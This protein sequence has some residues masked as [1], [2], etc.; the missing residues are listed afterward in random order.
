MKKPVPITM[1]I[2][3]LMTLIVITI[4][5]GG[6]A[7]ADGVLKDDAYTQTSTP[8]QN[9]GGNANLRV[10]SGIT[11]HLKFDLATLPS[12]ITGSDISKVTLRLWVNTVTTAGSFDVRRVIGV[13]NEGTVTSSTAPTLGSIDATGVAITVQDDASFVTVD[14]TP[15]VR[16]WL[17]GM[18]ANNGFALVANASTT[19]IRFDSKENG[20]TSHEPKL[21]VILK[22]PK[23]LNWTGAWTAATN[24][25]T[26]DAVSYNGSSWIAKQANTNVNPVEGSDWTIIARKG[27][28]GATGPQGP[29][30]ATGATGPQGPI[31][32]T[33]ATGVTGSQGPPGP[34]GPVGPQGSQG[35][36]GVTGPQGP[37]GPQGPQG[38]TGPQGPQGAPG[39]AGAYVQVKSAE[40][41]RVD[42]TTNA[43]TGLLEIT[44]S[45]QVTLPRPA[46]PGTARV[47]ELDLTLVVDSVVNRSYTFQ[48][49][50]SNTLGGTGTFSGT[51]IV[52]VAAGSHSVEISPELFCLFN[53]CTTYSKWVIVVKEILP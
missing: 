35:L 30:G 42:I 27:D 16:D 6:N 53:S 4:C 10:A 1:C 13:W 20:Q 38:P 44:F 49:S 34:A 11:S 5:L 15:L 8:N 21:E 36:T 47:H 48:V 51:W 2:L 39:A 32:P 40:A 3:R 19:N 25:A 41:E 50:D 45:V 7:F 12:G 37:E 52:P 23:G 22:E 43:A 29:V 14:L 28:T 26:G 31:G 17:D 46:P 18:L 9:F 24:Y 33:G